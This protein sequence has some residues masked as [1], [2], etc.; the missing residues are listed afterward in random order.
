MYKFGRNSHRALFICPQKLKKHFC[1]FTGENLVPEQKIKTKEDH[2]KRR[3][4]TRTQPQL[5]RPD[6]VQ[7]PAVSRGLGL[8][9]SSE[10]SPS[11]AKYQH[12]G[13]HVSGKRQLFLVFLHRGDEFSPSGAW[14]VTTLVGTRIRNVV[15][16]SVYYFVIYWTGVNNFFEE[17]AM[18]RYGSP[19]RTCIMCK[20]CACNL[21]HLEELLNVLNGQWTQTL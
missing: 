13:I 21:L 19:R 20:L 8:T 16:K 10:T 7:L 5:Q 1:F 4:A 9:G 3:T 17:Y 12:S 6:G 11:A 14:H 2:E 18:Y 15:L